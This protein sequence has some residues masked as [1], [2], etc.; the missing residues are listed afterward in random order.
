MVPGGE[1]LSRHGSYAA[2]TPICMRLL[3]QEARRAA[4]RAACAAAQGEQPNTDNRDNNEELHKRET[5]FRW[6]SK[7]PKV[8]L[9]KCGR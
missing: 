6:E 8:L 3:V 1:D 5:S 4:S 9:E 2:Q 7:H